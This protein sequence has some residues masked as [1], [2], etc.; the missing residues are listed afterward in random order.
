MPLTRLRSQP[1][2]PPD[3][4]RRSRRRARPAAVVATA[5]LGVSGIAVLAPSA[6]AA[7][8]D[9]VV[10]AVSPIVLTGEGRSAKVQ[11]RVTVEGGG[12][13]P[14]TVRVAYT[15]GTGTA[16]AG[17]DYAPTS[18]TLTFPVG[19]ASGSTRTIG[20]PIR[21][22]AGGEVAETVPVALTAD[23][24]TVSGTPQIVIDAHGL[25][26]LDSKLPVASRVADL[27][28]RMTL[29]EKI[30]QM[31]Q[32]ERAS[33]Y[34]D[35]TQIAQLG[36]GSLLSGG[37]STPPQNTPK[38]WADMIDTFQTNALAARLQVPIIYGIDTVHGDGNLYGA[39][40]FPHNIGI[41]A[42]RDA[43][44]SQ[45]EEHIAG[46]ETR[47]TGIPWV[48]APCLCAVRDE[49]WGRSYE[50]YG[51]D[52]A[53]VEKLETGI[54]GFQGNGS[55]DLAKSDRVLATI[56]HFA[57][58]GAT[59]YGS[60]ALPEAHGSG[61]PIDQ[62]IT[63]L[64]KADFNRLALAP[65]VPAV[66]Q[67]NAGSL[68][69]SYS[70]IDYTD[71]AAGPT[72][73]HENEDLIQGWLKGQQG[74]DGFV[75]SDYN[76]IDHNGGTFTEN[77]VGGVNAGIDLF[78]Q[79][80][81]YKDFI[82]TLTA[83]V[84]DGSVSQ[85]RIDDAVSRILTKKFQLGLFEKPFA[86][87]THA[88]AIGGATNR[89]VARK[90]VAESQVLLKNDGGALPLKANA[91]IYVA[92]RNADDLGNQEGGWTITWQGQSGTHTPGTTILQ[93]IK[94]VAPG[95]RV[96]YSADASAPTSGSDVGVVVVGETTYSEGFGDVGGP[97]WAYDPSDNGQPREAKSLSLRAQDQ[98]TVDKVCSA[99][100]TCVVLVVSGRTQVVGNLGSVDA[101]VA[102]FLPGSEGAGVADVL[103]GYKPFSGQLPVT[104]PASAVQEPINVGDASY[105]P[106]FPF[107]WGLTTGS[108]AARLT[109]IH[110]T[111]A[112]TRTALQQA[113]TPAYWNADGSAK[114]VAPVLAA[115]SSAAGSLQAS[116]ST[117]AATKVVGIA[118][119]VV[120][121]Q[122]GSGATALPESASKAFALADQALLKG[123][124][125]AA[126]TLL[127]QASAG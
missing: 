24:A 29:A 59:T 71:D 123:D 115:L 104:W 68:M 1:P 97:S 60:G 107:G 106:A 19:I 42:T 85:G 33:V 98:A 86:D 121:A 96:T 74:F 94:Q 48:F 28:S 31:T 38:A 23:G 112:A 82:T 83:A 99:L 35:P 43:A 76:G 109:G 62:G 80:N 114:Q 17:S 26:Y 57:G 10:S 81:N 16:T 63:Y 116:G 2:T 15:T 36:L 52:P 7:P 44:L 108:V 88:A 100:P 69:P 91:K 102:S 95:A 5:A 79:P 6:S 18:G 84:G 27:V 12:R 87:R 119:S 89:A 41:G 64:S 34:D 30:G 122:L 53:L 54:T 105:A 75:I 117:A 22:T 45:Q 20:V 55:T 56:K 127:T 51:E 111:D 25:P 120:Q 103:F 125:S 47:A 39:T 4:S 8:G 92:G 67:Y 66:K 72:N 11:V 61:Y 49:R 21:T 40:I 77:V 3:T 126:T 50:S 65:Y 37:G 90:A 124:V 101:L 70:S 73:M 13:L 14:S 118:R 78:M 110:G 58:D 93:G 9:V 46:T 32:A 113:S